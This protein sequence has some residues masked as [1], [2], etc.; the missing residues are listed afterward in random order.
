MSG[1]FALI[2]ISLVVITALKTLGY[3]GAGVSLALIIVCLFTALIKRAGE[4]GG[5]LVSLLSGESLRAAK[6]L[7]KIFGVS[8]LSS[9]CESTALAFGETELSKIADLWG[10]VEIIALLI[11]YFGAMLELGGVLL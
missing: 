4:I 9:I 2:F 5:E 3:K 7:T 1:I 8:Y 6:T 10:R 11:P